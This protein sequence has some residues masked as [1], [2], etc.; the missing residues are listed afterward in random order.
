MFLNCC[1]L[2]ITAGK[3][4]KP[5]QV[6]RM[7]HDLKNNGLREPI[8]VN[9]SNWVVDGTLRLLAMRFLEWERVP[10]KYG[11]VF[12]VGSFKLTITHSEEEVLKFIE[13]YLHEGI[14]KEIHV[15]EDGRVID[16]NLRVQVARKVGIAEIP[17][18]IVRS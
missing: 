16:G 7:V 18:K 1:D 10:V 5:H 12:D 17:Y 3:D 13:L 15:T 6:L 11:P 8:V 14:C 4:Y 2:K 9:L